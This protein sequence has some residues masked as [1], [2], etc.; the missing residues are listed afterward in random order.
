MMG[1]NHIE[2]NEIVGNGAVIVTCPGNGVTWKHPS[3][4]SKGW[5]ISP[6]VKSLHLDRNAAKQNMGFYIYSLHS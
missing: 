2:A 3:K 4:S 5:V 1:L 6:L